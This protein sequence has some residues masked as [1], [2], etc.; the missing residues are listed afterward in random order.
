MNTYSKYKPSNIKWIGD[1][2]EHWEVK[3]LKYA[4]EIIMGQSPSSEDYNSN[5]LGLPFLTKEKTSNPVN[6]IKS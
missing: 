5:N 3:K 6:V 4:D 2:P 1:I